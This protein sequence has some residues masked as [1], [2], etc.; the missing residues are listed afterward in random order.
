MPKK[1]KVVEFAMLN[2][3]AAGID[4]GSKEHWI[5]VPEGRDEQ[6]VRRFGSFT[7]DLHAIA[8]WLKRCR[9]TTIAMESTGVYWIPL[10]LI[11]EEYGFEVYL[12]NAKHVKNVSGKKTDEK[13]CRWIQRLHSCG[14]LTAKLSAGFEDE[15]VEELYPA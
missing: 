4:I 2:P 7:E 9:I 1:K 3:D 10:F 15:G 13:D 14:L 11:L 12:V 5:A 8:E 6:P